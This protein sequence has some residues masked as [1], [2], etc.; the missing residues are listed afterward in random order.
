MNSF[1]FWETTPFSLF[2]IS[3]KVETKKASSSISYL[4]HA[5]FLLGLFCDLQAGV[6]FSSEMPIDY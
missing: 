1:I 3:Q 4:L 5:G 2:K 6:T